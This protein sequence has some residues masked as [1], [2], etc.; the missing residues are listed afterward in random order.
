MTIQTTDFASLRTK[1]PR[2]VRLTPEQECE[3][4]RQIRAE[5]ATAR[6][7]VADLAPA[8]EI[9]ARPPG[10]R[11]RTRAGAVDRLEEAVDRV[12]EASRTDPSLRPA[13]TRARLAIQRAADLRW[14]LAMSARRIAVGEARRLGGVLVDA[15]DLIHEGFIGL[16]RAAK[17]FDPDRG[18]RFSTYA[19]W[20]VRAQITRAIDEGGRTIHMSVWAVE[21]ARNLR[22]LQEEMENAG[23]EVT[24]R[25]IAERLG[26]SVDRARELMNPA[27]AVSMETPLDNDGAAR[28]LQDVLTDE[29]TPAPDAVYICAEELDEMREAFV[30][31]LSPRE[32]HVL[33]RRFGLD[34]QEPGTLTQVGEELGL[35]RERIRQ[36]EAKAIKRLRAVGDARAWV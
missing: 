2:S 23:E 11:E 25:E 6:A 26:I 14:T 16:L 13:A 19:R 27:R 28:T 34:N 18:I 15:E 20:W 22:K 17:R 24:P 8:L 5:E 35:S 29:D 1:R 9:L 30:G 7:L 36:I 3:L 32:Q 31:A 21:Q 33:V 10:R 12:C 4:A